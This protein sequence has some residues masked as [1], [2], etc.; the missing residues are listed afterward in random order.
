MKD[1]LD[2]CELVVVSNYNPND[3]TIFIEQKCVNTTCEN[4][5]GYFSKS[6]KPKENRKNVKCLTCIEE[7]LIEAYKNNKSHT[8]RL[9]AN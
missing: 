6:G 7:A 2:G 4:R 5:I 3:K 9:A 8:M 1:I